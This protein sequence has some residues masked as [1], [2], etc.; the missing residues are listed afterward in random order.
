MSD[1]Q[2][3]KLLKDYVFAL[4]RLEYE[5]DKPRSKMTLDEYEAEEKRITDKFVQTIAATLG[6][7][8]LTAEQVR[9]C[10]ETVYLEG[11]SDGSVNRGAHIDETNWQAITDK[12]NAW[13][14]RTCKV[15]GEWEPFTQTQDLRFPSCSE[16]GYNFGREE[17]LGNFMRERC[18]I[19]NYCPNCGAKVVNE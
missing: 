7:G 15:V 8:T 3:S 9:E 16:C 1:N 17:R 19:P 10:A 6:S 12:L 5:A 14:E 4:R 18:E 11:Y 13:A 2:A